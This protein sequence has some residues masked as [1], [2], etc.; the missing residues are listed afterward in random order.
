MTITTDPFIDTN[1][2]ADLVPNADGWAEVGM[3]MDDDGQFSI[4]AAREYEGTTEG[5]TYDYVRLL[6][7]PSAYAVASDNSAIVQ[8]SETQARHMI[9][10]L[11]ASLAKLNG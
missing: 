8:V 6:I 2:N 9:D 3:G 4:S 11:T 7:D 10:L 1:P 5:V